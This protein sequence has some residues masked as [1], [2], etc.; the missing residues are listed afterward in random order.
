MEG[1]KMKVCIMDSDSIIFY[2][3]HQ[4][5]EEPEKSL[6]EIKQKLDLWLLDIFGKTYSTHYIMYLTEGLSFRKEIFTE[7][8][9]NRKDKEKPKYFN[10]IKEYLKE[11]YKASSYPKLEADDLCVITKNYFQKEEDKTA[12]Y[13]ESN[14]W[15]VFISSPDKDLLNLEGEHYDYRKGEWKFTTD[16]EALYY[17]FGSMLWGDSGDNVKGIPGVGVKGVEKIFKDI[18]IQDVPLVVLQV[19][20]QQY[21]ESLGIEN[22]YKTYKALKI[23]NHH[24]EFEK[25]IPNPVLINYE[26]HTE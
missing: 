9:A 22:Y 12:L 8:K 20:I 15:E 14:P 26:N 18:E 17:L 3:C 1:E 6:E 7:Y 19:Y 10:E 24:E 23:L 5:K 13:K 11:K 2:V 4:K 25:N 21:G 16:D